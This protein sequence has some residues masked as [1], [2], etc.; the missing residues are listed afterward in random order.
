VYFRG[1][2]GLNTLSELTLLEFYCYLLWCCVY[3]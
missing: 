3:C 2:E 1:Q